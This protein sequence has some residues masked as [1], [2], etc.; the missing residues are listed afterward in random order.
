MIF[1]DTLSGEVSPREK[2][3]QTVCHH[4]KGTFITCMISTYKLFHPVNWFLNVH[5]RFPE[6]KETD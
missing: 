1:S 2:F 4:K 3:S 6:T 5:S